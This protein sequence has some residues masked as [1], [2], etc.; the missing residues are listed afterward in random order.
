ML[1]SGMPEKEEELHLTVTGH[2]IHRNPISEGVDGW[3]YLKQLDSFY[4]QKRPLTGN[5]RFEGGCL[6]LE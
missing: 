3:L 1:L 6:L 5:P 2:K 4:S